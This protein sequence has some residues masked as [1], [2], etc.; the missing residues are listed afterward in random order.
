MGTVVN[1]QGVMLT[2]HF[3]LA[4]RLRMIIAM[5]VPPPRAFMARTETGF[6]RCI[7]LKPLNNLEVPVAS[8]VQNPFRNQFGIRLDGYKET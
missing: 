5:P 8:S 4:P 7:Q 3:L 2:S 6:N 1:D